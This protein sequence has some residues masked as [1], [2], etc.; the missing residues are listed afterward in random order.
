M[1]NSVD[2]ISRSDVD[3]H[4]SHGGL[5]ACT[6]GLFQFTEQSDYLGRRGEKNLGPGFRG[7]SYRVAITLDNG[8]DEFRTVGK[9]SNVPEW[10]L[11][12][13]LQETLA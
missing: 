2:L 1:A 12:E 8:S 6:I 3:R 10:S 4:I 5:C 7:Y 13:S 11:P 9:S